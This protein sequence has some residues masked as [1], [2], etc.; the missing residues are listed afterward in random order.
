MNT[1]YQHRT[2]TNTLKLVSKDGTPIKNQEV[3]V[4]QIKHKFLFGCN[5]FDAVPLVNGELEGAI[6]D[7]TEERYRNFF[8]IFN[9]ATMPFYWGRFE[10]EKG[11]PKTEQL[12]KASKWLISNDCTIKGHPLCWHTVTAPWLI[13]MSNEDI[14]KTQLDRINRDVSDFKGIIDMWDVINEVV[15]M[16]I[17]DKYDNGI[18][19][20]C[21]DLGR[22]GIIREM[23]AAT[24]R[25][26]PAAS[27]L[28]NDFDTSISYEILVEGC[29]E[30]GIPIDAI[31]IQSH[32]HQGYWGVE[33]TMKVLERFS[34]FNLPIH[35][36]E[37]SLV[38]GHIMPTEIEDLND[39]KLDEWPSTPEGEARQAEEVVTHYRTLF[40]HPLV[41]S[42][43][44]WDLKDGAWLGAPS[45]LIR[46][47]N[48]VKPAYEEL[49]KLIK[50]E[51]WTGTKQVITNEVG[52]IDFRGFLG[53]YEITCGDK[54]GH[55][56]LGKA[57]KEVTVV[58]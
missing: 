9:A 14:L 40:E 50:G 29:L 49:H 19:R 39:Y 48:S 26:N 43:T 23:F 56:T 51:W 31:G 11:H 44:W 21:K 13:D 25:A 20:I 30:A 33:K 2:A 37:N 7:Q 42:I 45:G 8:E 24:K 16:P 55:F 27:L 3:S 6:K 47:D 53:E 34:H 38:S 22:I 4:S 5:A 32:M 58:F 46:K 15:I 36:T 17:F 18:T 28:L 41:E 35:F 52:S 10:P 12:I 1:N 54:K 57:D